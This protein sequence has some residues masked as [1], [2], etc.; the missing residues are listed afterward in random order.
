MAEPAGTSGKGVAVDGSLGPLGTLIPLAGF[1]RLNSALSL[2]G[3]CV[4]TRPQ[5]RSSDQEGR[6]RGEVPFQPRTI[7][8]HDVSELL[9]TLTND[10]V[11]LPGSTH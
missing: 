7:P 8:D 2:V 10:G 3:L 5:R 4:T 6:A 11:Q 9:I 1:L